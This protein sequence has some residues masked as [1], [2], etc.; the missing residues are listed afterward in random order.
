MSGQ[1]IFVLS[2]QDVWDVSCRLPL[3][4]LLENIRFALRSASR[5]NND[6][7]MPHRVA[8]H[9]NAYTT[10]FMPS[11]V[12]SIPATSIKVVAVPKH[13]SDDGLPATTLVMD[14]VS[15]GLE[16]VVNARSLTAL[17]TA[18]AS[19]LAT[20]MSLGAEANPT[21]IVLFGAGAQ[22]QAHAAILV[23]TYPQIRKLTVIN[24]SHNQRLMTL[25]DHFREKFPGIQI[26]GLSGPSVLN[27]QYNVDIRAAVMTASIICTA[28]SSTEPLFPHDWVT[29]GT[30]INLIGSFTP[31]MREISSDLV[32]K[33]KWVIVDSRAACAKEAGELIDANFPP[34]E[35]IELGE[36][37][38][39][40]SL[41]SRATNAD[42]TITIFKSVGVS[43]M[44]TA[45][46]N[47]VVKGAR[48]LGCGTLIPYD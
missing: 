12:D 33:A 3:P 15:G 42:K 24:R 35:T 30:H 9:S 25:L 29:A 36:V 44:D 40:S 5:L 17:R 13:Q 47:L 10:L 19:A 16:A 28:T 21:S 4:E 20:K 27:G 6:V 26:V 23:A 46:A 14:E 48:E 7:Q 22:I 32:S 1:P 8:I 38:D 31:S 37:N 11:R 45:I 18:A 2:R 34:E 43:V 39:P 41:A